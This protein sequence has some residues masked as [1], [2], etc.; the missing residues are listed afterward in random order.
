[1]SGDQKQLK[2][3]IPSQFRSQRIAPSEALF[4][5]LLLLSLLSK[6]PGHGGDARSV[7]QTEGTKPV[8]S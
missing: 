8:E 3:L 5:C 4:A 6:D 2:A 1:M 7:S